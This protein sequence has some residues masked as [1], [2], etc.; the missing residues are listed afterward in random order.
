LSTRRKQEGPP[1]LEYLKERDVIV[2]HISY[3]GRRARYEMMIHYTEVSPGDV[4]IFNIDGL[5]TDALQ[6][7]FISREAQEG[8]EKHCRGKIWSH[9]L[10]KCANISQ[11]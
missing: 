9:N 2:G 4:L 11:N 6:C 8:F 3:G 10:E 1:E 7:A 5:E